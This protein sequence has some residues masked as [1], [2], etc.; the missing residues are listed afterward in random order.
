[1]VGRF[2][3]LALAM[4]GYKSSEQDTS[5]FTDEKGHGYAEDGKITKEEVLLM[6]HWGLDKMSAFDYVGAGATLHSA[7]GVALWEVNVEPELTKDLEPCGICMETRSL[8]VLFPCCDY[9]A[10]CP[11]CVAQLDKCPIC[12][13]IP[14]H[15]SVVKPF[16]AI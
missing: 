7:T 14:N 12:K 5:P 15:L 8:K 11:R 3:L 10:C 2:K 9:D 1:M 16:D 4:Y 13:T 6:A